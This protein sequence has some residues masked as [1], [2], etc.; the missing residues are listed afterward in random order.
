MSRRRSSLVARCGPSSLALAAFAP[1]L[2]SWWITDW[3]AGAITLGVQVALGA[4]VVSHSRLTMVRIF[5]VMIAAFSVGVSSWWLGQGVVSEGVT[6]GLRVLTMVLPGA[7]VALWVDPVVVG[8]SVAG[9]LRLSS[10]VVV[11][12]VASLTRLEWAADQWQ[13]IRRARRVRGVGARWSPLRRGQEAA[14]VTFSLLVA[15]L[16]ESNRMAVSM[17]ARGVP[18]RGWP[19]LDRTWAC[20]PPRWTGADTTLAVIA[21]VFVVTPIAAEL[22]V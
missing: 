1:I 20:P 19:G 8:D 13:Q 14:A 9:R 2:G 4:T 10:R 18:A 3:R 21:V 17:E 12:V 15:A 5:P 16:R 7:V 11:V 22:L 6:S